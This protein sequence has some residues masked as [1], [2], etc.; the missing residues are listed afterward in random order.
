MAP[1]TCNGKLLIFQ[2]NEL[3]FMMDRL[4]FRVPPLSYGPPTLPDT[5][6]PS[7]NHY[8]DELVTGRIAK[9]IKRAPDEQ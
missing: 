6:L 1:I 7:E 9:N 8:G 4:R 3:G 2:R 5:T